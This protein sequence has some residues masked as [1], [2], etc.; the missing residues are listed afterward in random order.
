MKGGASSSARASS[1][2]SA[3]A[4]ED[5]KNQRIWCD[6]CKMWLNGPDHYEDHKIGKRHKERKKLLEAERQQQPEQQQ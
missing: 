2:A 6:I 4:E 1:S 3:A 5:A